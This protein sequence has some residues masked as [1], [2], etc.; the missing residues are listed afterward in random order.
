MKNGAGL[1]LDEEP[2]PAD[3]TPVGIFNLKIPTGDLYETSSAA[4]NE[5]NRT[6]AVFCAPV[7]GYAFSEFV[8]PEAA[9]HEPCEYRVSSISLIPASSMIIPCTRWG[10]T[11]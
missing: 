8:S 2:M 6:G 7:S 3:K 4:R 1:R 9:S 5:S 11:T 10:C